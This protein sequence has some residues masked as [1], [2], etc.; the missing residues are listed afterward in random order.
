MVRR[1]TIGWYHFVPVD[2]DNCNEAEGLAGD[3]V[4]VLERWEP[5][6]DGDAV[7]QPTYEDRQHWLNVLQYG[8]HRYDSRSPEWFG[9]KI[10]ERLGADKKDAKQMKVVTAILDDLIEEGTFKVVSRKDAARRDREYVV[11]GVLAGVATP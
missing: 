4:G 8:E 6:K 7:R 10:A 1:G 9:F 11:P 5:P 3:S 2:L